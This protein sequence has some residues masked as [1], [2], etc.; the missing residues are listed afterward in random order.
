MAQQPV[1]KIK[2]MSVIYNEGQPTEFQALKDVNLEIY[3]DEYVIF[4]GPSG[5]GKSTLL[6]TIAG[7]ETPTDG[8]ITFRSKSGQINDLHKLNE[9]ELVEYHQHSIGMVFQAFYL[10]PSLTA[11]DNIILPGVLKGTPV[12]EREKSAQNF[13]KRFGIVEFQD[14]VPARLSG[15]Q[16]Q[17]VAIARSLVN[18]P[19]VILAD[20]PVGNLDSE[21]AAIVVDMISDLN[22][23][24]NKTVIHVTHDPRHLALADR[25]FY[26]K[27]GEIVRT[28][29]NHKATKPSKYTGTGRRS[30]VMNKIAT[31]HP[32]ASDSQMKAKLVI[33]HLL[34]PYTYYEM[35]RI[36]EIVAKYIDKQIDAKRMQELFDVSEEK[37]GVNLYK[38]TASKLASEVAGTVEEINTIEDEEEK[39]IPLRDQAIQLLHYLS[40]EHDF[41]LTGQQ[42]SRAIA[43]IAYR[44]SGRL[45]GEEFQELLD[46]SIK[47][48]GVGMHKRSA[49]KLSGE[50]EILLAQAQS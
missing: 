21:N 23:T 31:L 18:N 13:I 2:D 37:G 24:D 6:Y 16:Q 15:G 7:L 17:R 44:L 19:E 8:K 20:E 50:I 46:E 27:D 28:V 36:E 33:D 4:F 41:E 49:K 42:E 1:I 32:Y 39:H 29:V 5:S 25:V 48:G 34:L 43:A 40:D 35:E 3:E 9:E 26:I 11:R 38:Q 30:A 47:D 14:R 45:P 12:E 22:K 10:V